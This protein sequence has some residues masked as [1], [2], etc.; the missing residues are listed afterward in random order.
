MNRI[1]W[2]ATVI[3]SLTFVPWIISDAPAQSE[4]QEVQAKSL[5][6]VSF[7]A[8]DE[9][10]NPL[11]N[12]EV[13]I[14]IADHL[15]LRYYPKAPRTNAKGITT[16][17]DSN[18]FRFPQSN[19][20]EKDRLRRTDMICALF[21]CPEK[22]LNAV[23]CFDS[24]LDKIPDVHEITVTLRPA[25]TLRGIV[26]DADTQKPVAECDVNFGAKLHER[27]YTLSTDFANA[28]TNDAGE[29][30]FND[31][32][33]GIPGYVKASKTGYLVLTM[34][35]DPVIPSDQPIEVRVAPEAVS[36]DSTILPV[37]LPPF[38]GL[39]PLQA[40]KLLQE[41]FD[42]AQAE[43]NAQYTRQINN[44]ATFAMIIA[45]RCPYQKY[46]SAMKTIADANPNTDVELNALVWC[47][48]SPMHTEEANLEQRYVLRAEIGARLKEKYLDR[49]EIFDCLT[50]LIY[51]DKAE[52]LTTIRRLVAENP[53]REVQ[54]NAILIKTD[55]LTS[56]QF[57]DNERELREPELAETLKTIIRDYADVPYWRYENLGNMASMKLFEL[58]HLGIGDP[59]GEI[60]GIAIDGTPVKLSDHRGKVV[61]LFF[62]GSWCGPCKND[63]P[64]LNA[65]IA[66]DPDKAVVIGIM[67][68]EKADA[69]KAIAIEKVT[70]P[71]LVEA[72]HGPIHRLWNID[73]W[74]TVYI[75]DQAGKI[76]FNDF[77][78]VI[79]AQ[80]IR[81]R[82]ES[83]FGESH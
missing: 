63:V 49:P 22:N 26:I 50:E 82:V 64:E 12:V 57:S 34:V 3:V 53:S 10:G 81:N 1:I 30:E 11:S 32:V 60:E 5:S 28:T 8:V 51:S 29:F 83:L 54:G 40:F 79:G 9:G 17:E 42:K 67:A 39:E 31:L 13:R 2:N 76:R 70:W 14:E 4:E 19:I 23:W 58:E 16:P 27:F 6:S 24:N 20:R 46:L 52:S 36:K 25:V 72:E 56:R 15:S 75:V 44:P 66:K 21:Q 80:N 18:L 73:S 78:R 43:F 59:V 7:R 33:S 69:V 35:G 37:V 41:A 61:V 47:C 48:K 71:N 55:I 38:E 65:L 45:R 77:P 74:P 68:D 62:W